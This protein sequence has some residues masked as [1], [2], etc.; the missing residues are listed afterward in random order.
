MRREKELCFVMST[1]NKRGKVPFTESPFPLI[2][3]ILSNR[4]TQDQY[5]TCHRNY[6][7]N[8]LRVIIKQ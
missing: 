4:N 3:S 8:D 6:E 2:F 5:I 1:I 7:M